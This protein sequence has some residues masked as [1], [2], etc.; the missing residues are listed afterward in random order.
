MTNSDL[1]YGLKGTWQNSEGFGAEL[2]FESGSDIMYQKEDITT[3]LT[4]LFG[5]VNMY[6]YSSNSVTPYVF[7]GAGYEFLSENIQGDPDQG[8]VDAGVGFSYYLFSYLNVNVEV[9]TLYKL[10]SEDIDYTGNIGF[11]IAFDED[12]KLNQEGYPLVPKVVYEEA[13]D[14]YK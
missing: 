6:G 14:I 13:L 9:R 8:F 10:D 2:G 1:I 3:S 5:H 7:L 12:L 4:R 11:A